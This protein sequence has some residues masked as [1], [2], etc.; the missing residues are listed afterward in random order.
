MAYKRAPLVS[1]GLEDA[2]AP[3]PPIRNHRSPVE[4]PESE[5]NETILKGFASLRPTAKRERM[6]PYP[7]RLAQSQIDELE[8]LREEQ[9]II[10]AAFIR[11]AVTSCLTLLSRLPLPK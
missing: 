1:V 6:V 2:N 7:V 3:I 8:R 11:D 5:G 10:P 4:A 9:G